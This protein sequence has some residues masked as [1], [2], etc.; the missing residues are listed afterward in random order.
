LETLQHGGVIVKDGGDPGVPEA[1]PRT[2]QMMARRL[3]ESEIDRL[4]VFP[5][6]IVGRKERG[7]VAAS[8]FT[9]DGAR[10]LYTA[11]YAA[12]RTGTSLS[13]E[14]GIA[15]EG[16]APPDRL[17]RVMQGVVRRSEIDLGEPRVVKIAGDSEKLRALLDE[18]D[19]DLLEPVVT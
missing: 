3:G 6:L 14:N 11:P 18:F 7:L 17:A 10:R 5:P 13:V 15:E 4:W 1:I 12:E 9:E 19:A 8:C 16:Q 2:L